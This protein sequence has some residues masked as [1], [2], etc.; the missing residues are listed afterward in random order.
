MAHQSFAQK[1]CAA[2]EEVSRERG[3]VTTF[4]LSRA[5]CVKTH[6]EHKAM[7]STLSD[8]FR[9]GRVVRIRH[10]VYRGP[11]AKP[12]PEKREVMWRILR[13]RKVVTIADLQAFGNVSEAYARQ[14]LCMLVRRKIVIPQKT[15]PRSWRLIKHDLV[16]MPCDTAKAE[17]LR[18]LRAE[19][20]KIIE[21]RLN[22]IAQTVDEIRH[23]LAEMEVEK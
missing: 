19:K 9:S 13:M 4:E 11:A 16:E 14:W 17:K 5:L 8:L 1:V 2:V 18:K 15:H 7:I 20:K 6:K 10:G 12:V 21:K 3:Q 23:D 22:N